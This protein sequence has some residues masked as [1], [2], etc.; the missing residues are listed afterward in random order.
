MT[1][2]AS[3]ARRSPG[4][5]SW[6]NWLLFAVAVGAT[7]AMASPYVLLDPAASRIETTGPVHYA[8]LVTHVFTASVALVLGPLQFVGRVRAHRRVHRTI[9]RCYLLLGVLPSALAGIPLAMLSGRPVTQI[10]LTIPFLGWLVTGWLAFRAVRR[11][12]VA[13]HRDWMLRNV[14]LTFLA[15]TARI[16]VPV[17]LLVQIPFSGTAA[18]AASVPSL[19]AVGRVLGWVI[20]LLLVEA[21]IRR[22]RR[23]AHAPT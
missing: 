22:R 21:V 10:G 13:A 18:L 19:I 7:A 8:L 16:L 17:M 20:N 23:A 11:G 9:G 5:R 2:T 6:R 3:V 14:A 4:G 12:D 15:V 1:T